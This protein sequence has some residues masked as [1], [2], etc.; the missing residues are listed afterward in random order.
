MNDQHLDF[1][2]S[3]ENE[4]EFTIFEEIT[5]EEAERANEALKDCPDPDYSAVVPPDDED[6]VFG[7]PFE[8]E[9]AK[10]DDNAETASS[11]EIA[12]Y[13]YH[14]EGSMITKEDVAAMIEAHPDWVIDFGDGEYGITESLDSAMR[15]LVNERM[16]KNTRST[17][18]TPSTDD[19][20]DE[21]GPMDEDDVP[22]FR[23]IYMGEQDDD[24][25]FDTNSG[26]T[27]GDTQLPI[28]DFAS[29]RSDG[30]T[31]VSEDDLPF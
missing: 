14:Y 18:Y 11:L 4:Q 10:D 28:F 27:D 21:F 3:D 26:R 24:L 12:G 1:I 16:K 20:E 7:F 8:E 17:D 6:C 31:F 30:F 29:A 22:T 25:P 23:E 5:E 13:L 19:L 9:P 15:Q 2:P